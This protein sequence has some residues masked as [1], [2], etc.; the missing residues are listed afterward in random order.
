MP[1]ATGE[2]HIDATDMDD[3]RTGD[4]DVTGSQ[5]VRKTK[6]IVDDATEAFDVNCRRTY[7]LR[8]HGFRQC[9]FGRYERT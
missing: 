6:Q 2:R 9:R 5:P 7:R 8:R 1:D 3:D 4:F